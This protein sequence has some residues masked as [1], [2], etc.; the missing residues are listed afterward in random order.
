[1]VKALL[2]MC[3]NGAGY[4]AYAIG[5]FASEPL[6]GSDILADEL[7]VDRC[8]QAKVENLADDISRLKGKFD[9]REVCW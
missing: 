1:M 8:R 2:N 5:E 3:V 9:T 6:I 7:D 4:G